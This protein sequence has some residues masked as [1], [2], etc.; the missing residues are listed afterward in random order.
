[1]ILI[2]SLITN[3]ESITVLKIVTDI[4]RN[5]NENQI[6]PSYQRFVIT[7]MLKTI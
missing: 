7:K 5:H 6:T 3:H 4:K 1:M 2:T